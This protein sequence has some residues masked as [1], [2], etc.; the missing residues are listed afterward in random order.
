MAF[1]PPGLLVRHAQ[2]GGEV[3]DVLAGHLP[4]TRPC[5]QGRLEAV[6]PERATDVGGLAVPEELRHYPSASSF[7]RLR[8]SL[9]AGADADRQRDETVAVVCDGHGG[10]TGLRV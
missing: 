4:R 3:H 10:N 7:D 6:F 5:S 9:R 2:V 1:D 8:A